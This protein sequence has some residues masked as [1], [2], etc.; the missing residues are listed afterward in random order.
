M[1]IVFKLLY[2]YRYCLS[3]SPDKSCQFP[4][5]RCYSYTS[6]FI[7]PDKIYNA[8]SSASYS[9]IN[10]A[11]PLSDWPFCYY[12]SSFDLSLT[13]PLHIS[14][15]LRPKRYLR[16]LLPALMPPPNFSRTQSQD[17]RHV[18][19][20]FKAPFS[21]INDSTIYVLTPGKQLNF[22]TFF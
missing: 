19:K 20:P 18:C 6:L 3:S 5:N 7:I 12:L 9:L 14:P 15:E 11:T 10:K 17:M 16:C 22:F 1:T 21:T 4:R 2:V 8:K 13:T